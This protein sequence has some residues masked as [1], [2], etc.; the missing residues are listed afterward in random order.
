M[1]AKRVDDNQK[2]IVKQLRQMGISV[3]HLHMIGQGMPDLVLGFRGVNYLIEL[4]DGKKISSKKK[5]TDD[6]QEFFNDWR[7]Q[8]AKCETLDEIIK[9]VG[10]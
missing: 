10:L 4:K 7:G 3:R 9:I 5:L 2:Q 1:R 6:E 8:V